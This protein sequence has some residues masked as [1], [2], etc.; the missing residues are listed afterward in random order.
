M[1]INI[2]KYYIPYQKAKSGTQMNGK[3]FSAL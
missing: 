2:E 3:P 1:N